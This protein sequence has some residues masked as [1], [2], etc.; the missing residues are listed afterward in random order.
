MS[1]CTSLLIGYIRREGGGEGRRGGETYA[2]QKI[3]VE[4]TEK[5]CL[6][7]HQLKPVAQF[8]SKADRYNLRER[9][10]LS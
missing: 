6:L 4:T 2:V 1:R 3:V 7:L 10:A 9:G 5:H 8:V